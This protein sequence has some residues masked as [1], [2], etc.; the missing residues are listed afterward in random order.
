MK[1]R[2]W[3]LLFIGFGALLVLI[4]LS[5][6]VVGRRIDHVRTDVQKLQRENQE[7]DRT[8]DELRSSIYRMAVLLRDYVLER[9]PE[10][11][12]EQARSIDELHRGTQ[13]S[14]R[15]LAEKGIPSERLQIQQLQSA[16]EE[17]WKVLEP[18][19]AWDTEKRVKDGPEYLLRRVCS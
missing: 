3:P 15:S 14:Y 17:Y 9:S 19:L 16:I 7:S 12:A 8:F 11:A 2:T 5:A 10:A 13:D 6:A 18:V 4:G 1:I